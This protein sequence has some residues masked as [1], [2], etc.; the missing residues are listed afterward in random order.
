MI[1]RPGAQHQN[2]DSLS[3]KPCSQCGMV[4]EVIEDHSCLVVASSSICPAWTTEEV[5]EMQSADCDLQQVIQW[6]ESN[7]FLDKFPKQSTAVVQTLEPTEAVG[8]GEWDPLSQ[9]QRC[10]WWWSAPETSACVAG[11]IC[12]RRSDWVARFTGGGPFGHQK[13]TRKRK[14][15]ILLARS[16]E[17]RGTLMQKLFFCAIPGSRQPNLAPLYTQQR[18]YT[19]LC[20]GLQWVLCRKLSGETD[21]FL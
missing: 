5:G 8:T 7:S 11:N 21:T 20:N 9:V 15:S 14:M 2:A 3:R 4:S 16:E 12:S 6:V 10:P 13:D 1:H 19:C 18:M 17:G